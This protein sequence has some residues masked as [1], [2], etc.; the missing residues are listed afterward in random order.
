MRI[1]IADL[2]PGVNYGL[3]LRSNTDDAVSDW[4]RVFYITTNS[5]VVAPKTPTGFATSMSGTS[6]DA[7]WA[8][9]TQSADNTPASDL[10]HYE[11]LVESTGTATNKIYNVND[12]KFQFNIAMNR[13]LFG[14]PRANIIMSVR[15]V[16]K[17]GN[18]SAYT[19]TSS[20]TNPAPA[21]PTAFSGAS[22]IDAINLK[23]TGVTDADLMYYRIY[24]GTTA[25]TQTNL[26]WTGLGTSATISSLAYSVDQYYKVAAVDVFGTESTTPPVAG[27]YRPASSTSVDV[28][29][30]GTPTN[31]A[32]TLTNATDGKTAKAVVTWDAVVDTDNDLAEYI[33]AYKPSAETAWQT[34]KVDYE[35]TS[36][37]ILGLLPYANYDFRIRA[38]DFSANLSGWTTVLT[39][40]ATANTA[41]AQVTGVA[42]A[43][44]R[45]SITVSWNAN[46]EPDVANGAGTYMVDVATN[47]GFTTGLLSYK[48]GATAITISGLA[49]NTQYWARVKAV[50]TLGLASTLWS[51]SA[52]STTLTFPVTP[53]SDGNP[54]ASSPQPTLVGGLGYLWASWTPISNNDLVT[55]EVHIG[56]TSTFTANSSTKV[57]EIA[58]STMMIDRL[59]GGT[60]LA[61]NTNYWAKIIAKDI[62][63]PAPASAASSSAAQSLKVAAA[64]S[65]LD[66]A[67]VGAATELYVDNSITTASNGKNKIVYSTSDA[68]GTGYI[69]GDTWRKVSSTGIGGKVIKEWSFISGAWQTKL[70]S[71]LTLTDLDATTINTGFLDVD[72]LIRTNAITTKLLAVGDYKNY[73]PGGAGE[74]GLGGIWSGMTGVSFE[75]TDK[76]AEL[77]GVIKTA[78]GTLTK[79]PAGG[80]AD[81]GWD[82]TPGEELY[83]E[84]W[85]KADISGSRIFVELRDQAGAH[86][87][88]NTAIPG[89]TFGGATTYPISNLTVPTTWTKYTSLAT[90]NATTTRLRVA[91][92]YF[93]HSAGTTQAASQSIAIRVRRRSTGE[94]LVDGTVAA[95]KITAGTYTGGQFIVGP[96]GSIVTNTGGVSI[97]DSGISIPQGHLDA[98]VLK[99]NTAFV[100]TLN[101]GA[102]G[103]IQSNGYTPGGTSGF[104]LGENGLTIKGSANSVDGGT[105]PTSTLDVNAIKTSTLTT[106]TLS[107]GASG[108]ISVGVGGTISIDGSTGQLKSNNYALNSTGYR[109]SNAGL[110]VNDGSIDAKA[111]R[112][113]TAVIGDLTIGRSADALGTIKSFDYAAGTTGWKI[114]KG[115][116]EINNGTIAA[117]AL[118]IQDSDNLAKPEYAGFE[119]NSAFY[120]SKVVMTGTT[121][122]SISTASP[123]Y[124]SQ[125]G[126]V[127]ATAAGANFIYFGASATDYTSLPL[128]EGVT[129]ILSGW[130]RASTTSVVNLSI[131]VRGS[132]GTFLTSP[133]LV[134]PT[135]TWTRVSAAF[136]V[137][138]GF[139]GG[140]LASRVDFAA[141]GDWV[142]YDGLQV[143]RKIAN[144][145]NPSPW[146]PPGITSIEGGMFRTGQIQSNNL[147][148]VAG[149]AQPTWSI[150]M[151]GNAQ[152]GDVLLRGKLVVGAS[153]EA[154]PN[155][156][157]G[158]GDFESNITGYSVFSAGATSP[159]IVRTT[160]AGERITGAGSAKATAA[161]G[162]KTELGISWSTPMNYPVGTTVSVSA[163]IKTNATGGELRFVGLDSLGLFYNESYGTL[164]PNPAAN[165]VYSVNFSIVVPP[166]E[167]LAS[168][169]IAH[170]A[171]GGHTATSFIMDDVIMTADNELG[172]SYIASANFQS[173]AGG[174]GY[175]IDSQTVEINNGYF[176]GRLG[177][178]V[179]DTQ[180]LSSTI[181]ISSEFKTAE[182][183]SRLELSGDG[184]FLYRADNSVQISLPTDD[185]ATAAFEGDL[186]A[187]SLTV[188][189][190]MAIRG[191]NN[192]LSRGAT[193]NL[194]GGT[195]APS[196]PPTV[197]VDWNSIPATH[198]P[199]FAPYRYGVAVQ[200]GW[201][202]IPTVLY[203]GGTIIESYSLVDGTRQ[204]GSLATNSTSN[205]MWNAVGGITAIGN[206]VYMLGTNKAGSWRIMGWTL[207]T[208]ISGTPTKFLDV[209]YPQAADHRNP[210]I[211]NDGTNLLVALTNNTSNLIQWRK[212]NATTGAQIGSAIVTNRVYGSDMASING[213][214]FDF[215]ASRV[216]I[217][218]RATTQAWV[219]DSTTGVEQT[220]QTFPTPSKPTGQVYYNSLFWTFDATGQKIYQH[221]PI[222]W[223]AAGDEQWHV[224]NTW[225][226]N[227]ATGGTHETN[228]SPIR[229]ITMK[230]RAR[231]NIVTAPLPVRPVPNTTDDAVATGIYMAKGAVTPTYIKMERQGY[232]ATGV[233]SASYTAVT[234]PVAAANSSFPPPATSNFGSQ[235][236]ATLV[237]AN[238]RFSVSGDGAGQWADMVVGSTGNVSIPSRLP[239]KY[240]TGTVSLGIVAATS[241]TQSVSV[242]FPSAFAVAPKVLVNTGSTRLNA[243]AISV[244]TSGFTFQ[245]NNFTSAASSA[246]TGDWVAIS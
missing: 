45:D 233:R 170:Y 136:T 86:G 166:N 32:A 68:S 163:N 10:D 62:D 178:Q 201:F 239:T 171:A 129:Y 123:K 90:V 199:A 242:T 175:K 138:V 23:W 64:D 164:I 185:A 204:Y 176:R 24:Q 174:A 104:R 161:A 124:Q 108:V 120:N 12:T 188:S 41:P 97:T 162:T 244:T 109:L 131:R 172:L 31:L 193:L 182:T 113:N 122:F 107:L 217:T 215:G 130:M 61:F 106:T 153:D 241:G 20:Q 84:V 87:T 38:A 180:S 238:S 49:A 100:T 2:A 186:L 42:I 212:F 11:V 28:T 216:V 228:M 187:S 111:L 168:I 50:D 165:T 95:Q 225:Y 34:M 102:G 33:L 82:V 89:T 121:T 88:T 144:S 152:L 205:G 133:S 73:V 160:T 22:T 44:G 79:T 141:A 237:S 198:D 3:R 179:V 195:T 224:S 191:S 222:T 26:V 206:N 35:Q 7:S 157:P 14:T 43:P 184:V 127:T 59:N 151:N 149:V 226:D 114:G 155:R 60:A 202:R 156:A 158:N 117:G 91:S 63:G 76:P 181:I 80:V 143:E 154:L 229:K 18:P 135:T 134:S 81:Y 214:N 77:P 1:T 17:A 139:P 211:G 25:G 52:N 53:L 4:S 101:I 47:S 6:F 213:G 169:R 30:P 207:G 240:A 126:R 183:G 13:A 125:A 99:G 227:N 70:Y 19:S 147:I 110:E 83:V 16:D 189:D 221:T 245:V 46:T 223:T 9:V 235:T 118:V 75:T 167:D 210:A 150:N 66:A 146:T 173:G 132:D 58:G 197:T 115:L 219:F 230:K 220:T 137:P 56:T 243:A 246:T 116:F 103:L 208:E 234:L 48:T 92:I 51:A 67:A 192:E 148:T 196:T 65:S 71:G 194:A 27:P 85:L 203:G 105:I 209:S 74:L 231:I 200:G 37:T 5:D 54:P 69:D 218:S 190:Q 57:G 142:E 232:L 140:V 8:A 98:N 93:N 119:F 21:N 29:A 15:A 128:E 145:N 55:Y 112:T 72:N 96:G 94:L 159:A 39:K 78:P 177:A 236:P 36:A 40:T